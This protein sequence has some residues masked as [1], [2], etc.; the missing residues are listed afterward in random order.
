MADTTFDLS[1]KTAAGT[2]LSGYTRTQRK[3]LRNEEIIKFKE[4]STKLI[5]PRPISISSAIDS[6]DP[7]N[8][9]DK[10]N[11]FHFIGDWREIVMKLDR[12]CTAYY[13]SNVFRWIGKAQRQ[14]RDASGNLEFDTTAT[15]H[16]PIVEEYVH[17]HG[18][19]FELWHNMTMQSVTGACQIFYEHAEDVDRQNLSWTYEL[20]MANLD[21]DLQH[22][23]MS[24]CDPLPEWGRTGPVAFYVAA[25][26]IMSVTDNIAHNVSSGIL[27]LRLTHFE[28]ED[29]N[30]C[31]FVLRNSLKFLNHGSGIGF[32]K[33]PPTLMSAEKS[34]WTNRST[35]EAALLWC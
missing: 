17:D 5:L 7:E 13:Y 26:R 35:L 33:S 14:K 9:R 21:A 28:G 29:V 15:P 6:F 10:N 11:F 8:L 3:G 25:K 24:T 22:F 34:S 27:N 19:M 30:D 1:T 18:N 31:V 16:A 12:H 20:I 4:V 32:D 2:K 23:V